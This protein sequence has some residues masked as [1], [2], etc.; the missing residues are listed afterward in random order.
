VR[1]EDKVKDFLYKRFNNFRA[2]ADYEEAGVFLFNVYKGS[3]TVIIDRDVLEYIC[4]NYDEL[5]IAI[6]NGKY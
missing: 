5:C 3:T 1:I 4:E 6:I 2:N